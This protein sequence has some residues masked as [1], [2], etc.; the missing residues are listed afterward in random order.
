[1]NSKILDK[2]IAELKTEKPKIDYVLGMLET[3][4]EMSVGTAPEPTVAPSVVSKA[5]P[6][7]AK[8][9]YEPGI[10]VPQDRTKEILSGLKYE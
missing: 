4:R 3:L 6:V 1:M 2:C 5:V 8:I 10:I 9:D 7:P